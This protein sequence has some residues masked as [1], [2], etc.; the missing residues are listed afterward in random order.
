MGAL[1]TGAWCIETAKITDP[2]YSLLY[3]WTTLMVRQEN[4]ARQDFPTTK[5]RQI[6]LSLET[7]KLSNKTDKTIQGTKA[8]M[9]GDFSLLAL[10]GRIL[11]SCQTPSTYQMGNPRKQN[12]TIPHQE[13]STVAFYLSQHDSLLWWPTNCRQSW[14][15]GPVQSLCLLKGSLSPRVPEWRCNFRICG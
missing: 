8:R 10:H 14:S 1:V 9:V 4:T 12:Q 7:A 11:R 3:V 13:A 2:F 15:L 6:Q 5:K